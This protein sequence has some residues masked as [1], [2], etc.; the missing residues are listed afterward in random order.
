MRNSLRVAIR[1]VAL[2]ALAGTARAAENPLTYE[3]LQRCDL[4]PDVIML[5]LKYEK[6]VTW[7]EKIRLK[8]YD[9][10][11]RRGGSAAEKSG[12][13]LYCGLIDKVFPRIAEYENQQNR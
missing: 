4:P 2:L 12:T 5:F 6:R 9:K 11:A 3:N 1:L 10:I 8:A 13:V 7:S